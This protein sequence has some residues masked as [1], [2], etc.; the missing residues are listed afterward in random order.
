MNIKIQSVRFDADKKLIH[1]INQKLKKLGQYNER[2]IGADVFLRL[3]KSNDTEN[4]ITEI[5]LDIPKNPLFAKRQCKTFEE[6]TDEAV[7]ALKRQITKQKDKLR[8]V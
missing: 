8:G 3:D 7:N 6:A 5:R 4:K 2:I 1:F